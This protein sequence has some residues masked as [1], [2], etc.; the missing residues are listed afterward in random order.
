MNWS[1]SLRGAASLRLAATVTLGPDC[2]RP[3]GTILQLRRATGEAV[4]GLGV[5]QVMNHFTRANPRMLSGFA[6][7]GAPLAHRATVLGS[8]TKVRYRTA[9]FDGDLIDL[10]NLERFDEGSREWLP[11]PEGWA[12]ISFRPGEHLYSIQR[13]GAAVFAVSTERVICDGA[14]I[15]EMNAPAWGACAFWH[16]GFLHVCCPGYGEIRSFAW[17]PGSGPVGVPALTC[18][19]GPHYGRAFGVLGGKVLM[20]THAGGLH[21]FDGL[22]W[23]DVQWSFPGEFYALAQVGETLRLGDYGSGDQ[24]LYDPAAASVL[25][26]L[27]DN[28]PAEPGAQ[29]G[30]GREIQSFALHGGALYHGVYPWG[31][32]HWRD[33]LNWSWGHQRLFSGPPINAALGAFTGEL[34]AQGVDANI[35]PGISRWCQRITALTAWR[36]GVVASCTNMPGDL[37]VP[38]Q[39][40]EAMLG[41]LHGEYGRTILLEGPAAA[42][43]EIT[44]T[45]AP[46]ELALQVDASRVLLLQDGVPIA[47]GPGLVLAEL[48]AG[49]LT[50][51][52]GR[53]QFGQF[54]GEAIRG[55]SVSG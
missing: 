14:T 3:L 4:I 6:R 42:A 9:V 28:P 43:G 40:Q 46:T 54:G 49:D 30:S 33:L 1:T 48:A 8:A 52:V 5:P 19:L 7:S 55:V 51:E 29:K 44:W 21:R 36:G 13:I 32:V 22:S 35:F 18:L 38:T 23:S 24:W 45:N 10:S 37:I 2:G 31:A 47:E 41:N 25:Q 12:G 20:A 15:Y 50:L 17:S 11:L 53:G 16:D 34:M 26:K 27:Q 39:A